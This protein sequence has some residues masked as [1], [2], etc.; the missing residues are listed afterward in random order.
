MNTVAHFWR[1]FLFDSFSAISSLVPTIVAAKLPI[2]KVKAVGN[3]PEIPN[4]IIT[5]I[6]IVSG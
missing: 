1:I 2:N 6:I 4:A 5:P 3:K